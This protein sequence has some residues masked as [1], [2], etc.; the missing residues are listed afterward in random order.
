MR[1]NTFLTDTVVTGEGERH[2]SDVPWGIFGG[3]DGLNA[4]VVKNP[5]REGEESWPSKVTG[6]QLL[7]GDSI[8]ITVPSGGGFGD[9]KKRDPQKVLADVLDGFTDQE[10]ALK[11]YKVVLEEVDGQLQVNERETQRLRGD[12][13]KMS[14]DT[15][16]MIPVAP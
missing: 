16:R 8:Q 14:V 11:D 9:P 4:S 1:E 10:S 7:A 2:E 5:G 12:D 15:S 13:T 3:H 6:R